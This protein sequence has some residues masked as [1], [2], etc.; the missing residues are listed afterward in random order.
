MM[1][2]STLTSYRVEIW[3]SKFVQEIGTAVMECQPTE[4]IHGLGSTILMPVW[5]PG[6]L[7]GK[8]AT[9]QVAKF[10]VTHPQPS[11]SLSSYYPV[12][13]SLVLLCLF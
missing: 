11:V 13:L 3:I 8:T 5:V 12:R 7:I 6:P 9:K 10:H 1:N 4:H 2:G